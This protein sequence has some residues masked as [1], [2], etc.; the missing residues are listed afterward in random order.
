[1]SVFRSPLL[2]SSC[3]L[4]VGKHNSVAG[5]GLAPSTSCDANTGGDAEHGDTGGPRHEEQRSM[6]ERLNDHDDDYLLSDSSQASD[7]EDDLE[8]TCKKAR[9]QL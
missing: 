6:L 7:D 4:S 1:M 2:S 3:V 8:I 9:C 5:W